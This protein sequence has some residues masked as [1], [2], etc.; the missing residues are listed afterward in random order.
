[1]NE[2]T[3]A[4]LVVH[5][6]R[7]RVKQTEDQPLLDLFYIFF[8]EIEGMR[9]KVSLPH[10]EI[11]PEHIRPGDGFP[12]FTAGELPLDM[13]SARQLMAAFLKADAPVKTELQRLEMF[14]EERAENFVQVSELFLNGRNHELFELVDK[15]GLSLALLTVLLQLALWP[16]CQAI[17]Q[18]EAI[19][20]A[21]STWNEGFCPLCG[22]PPMMSRLEKE[23]QRTLACGLCHHEW[24]FPRMECPFC[25]NQDQN[26]LF[27]LFD[28]REEGYRIYA[29][30][31]CQGYIKAVDARVLEKPAPLILENLVTLHLDMLAQEKGLTPNP[32]MGRE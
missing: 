27:Y 6:D 28:E 7:M 5:L 30:R 22:S 32:G 20:L 24:N 17:R 4:E 23:G 18:A 14:F 21:E 12:L 3:L 25:R 29:C 8:R 11:I 2:S 9:L 13:T 10:Y 26:S 19:R 16:S 31:R 1:M 15:A